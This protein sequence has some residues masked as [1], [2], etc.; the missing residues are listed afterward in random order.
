MHLTSLS[1]ASFRSL[2]N[3]DLQ[4]LG[5]I[6]LLVGK[7]N[8][9]KTSV[10]EAI[11]LYCQPLN[12]QQW[13]NTAKQR[14]IES[15]SNTEALQ[16]MFPSDNGWHEDI[17]IAGSNNRT[18]EITYRFDSFEVIRVTFNLM[19][20]DHPIKTWV[21][22]Q[23]DTLP[24]VDTSHGI[25][26]SWLSSAPFIGCESDISKAEIIAFLQKLD[27]E[28]SDIKILKKDGVYLQHSKSG[29]APIS[30][31]GKGINHLFCLAVQIEQAKD[32]VLLIDEIERS[33][34]V[35]SLASFTWLAQWA[36][37]CNVQI[38]ATTHSLEVIDAMINATESDDELVLHRLEPLKDGST[39]VVRHGWERLGRLRENLGYEV[40]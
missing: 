4:G 25:P 40:R 6:N 7:N 36:K 30:V 8:S 17:S 3:L 31:F 39:R 1:I 32:G 38:F 37:Q 14:S 29:L 28:I 35:E 19:I 2:Q 22:V 12:V 13:I 11:A 24:F 15:C 33:I 9:G 18:I 27:P 23:D 5:H 26:V 34:H 21:H 16:W 10:L 20:A